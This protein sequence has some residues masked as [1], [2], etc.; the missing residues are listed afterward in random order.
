MGVYALNYFNTG[1]ERI[2]SLCEVVLVFAFFHT[3]EILAQQNTTEPRNHKLHYHFEALEFTSVTDAKSP[4]WDH[5]A[6]ILYWVDALN[7]T[8]HALNYTSK[9]HSHK[10]IGMGELNV[11]LPIAGSKRLLL[12]IQSF[13]YLFDWDE[14]CPFCLKYIA[15]LDKGSPGNILNEGKADSRGRFWG[16][17]RGP[18]YG[19]SILQDQGALYSLEQ[20]KFE[21]TVQLKPVSATNGITWSLN[22][23]ILYFIDSETKKIDAFDFDAAKGRISKRRTILNLAE[24]SFMKASSTPVA[25]SVTIDRNGYLW[26]ALMHGGAVIRVNP[27]TKKIVG[28]Y[29]LPVSRITSLSWAGPNLEELIVTTSQRN[30]EKEEIE[31]EPLSGAL[32][33]LHKLGTGGVPDHKLSFN[34]ADNF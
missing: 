26:V 7:Q 1:E 25:H 13:V 3:S 21:P 20:P 5:D 33:I 30:M 15:A 28:K 4:V 2:M 19:S 34:D 32:Y 6:N 12:G 11:V 23:S 27:E 8:V 31:K 24:Y 16:G 18:L 10:H 29:K 17:T 9:Q 14:P 22:N